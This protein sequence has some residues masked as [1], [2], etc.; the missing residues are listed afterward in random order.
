MPNSSPSCGELPWPRR[1]SDDRAVARREPLRDL[2]PVER[3]RAR[4]AVEEDDR[5]AAAALADGDTPARDGDGQHAGPGI[6]AD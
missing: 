6:P 3:A 5:D 4:A 1:S 2:A